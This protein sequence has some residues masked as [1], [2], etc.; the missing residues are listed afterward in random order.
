MTNNMGKMTMERP[1]LLAI[2]TSTERAGLALSQDDEIITRSWDAGRTQTTT[3]LPAIDEMLRDAG[4]VPADLTAVAVATGP[5]TF[6]GLRVGVSVAKGIVLARRIP[7]VGIPTLDIVAAMHT[8][9][10]LI[11]VL[12]AG[13]GRIVWQLWDSEGS[14][15]PVNST[16]DE[17]VTHLSDDM[18]LAGELPDALRAQFVDSPGTILWEPR[19]PAILLRLGQKRIDRG[20]VDDAEALEPTYLHGAVGSSGPVQDRLKRKPRL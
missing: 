13:R 9:R 16:P 7:L 17:A 18:L 8:M 3:V 15:P 1:I 19:D 2:D 4:L 14:H 11:A 5:G 20:D 12:P 10:P 6:T